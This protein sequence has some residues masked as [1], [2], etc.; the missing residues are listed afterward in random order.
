MIVAYAPGGGTDVIARAMQPFTSQKYLGGKRQDRGDEPHRVPAARIGFGLLAGA[1]AGRL[2]DRLHQHAQRAD[3]PDRAQGAPSPGKA[4]TCSATSSTTRATSR[5]TPTAIK[6]LDQLAT[7]TPRRTRAQLT[8]GT[9]GVGSDDHLAMLYFERIAGVKLTHVPFKGAA[10]VHNAI[11]R[12]ADHDVAAMNIGEALQYEKGGTPLRNLGQMSEQRTTWRRT[13][14]RSRNRASTS[15]M[16]SLRGMAAPKG[17]PADV[18]ER[19]VKAVAQTTSDPEFLKVAAGLFTQMRY[20]NPDQYRT[21]LRDTE[22]GF[23][24][25]WTEMPWGEK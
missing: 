14:P 15:I 19:L 10:E 24:K 3:D 6:N 4:S 16:A 12:Q 21:V 11:A 22:A 18:R 25:L 17:L 9:T 2:H 5:C 8:Y 7:P 23:R 20:L 13:C 1:P